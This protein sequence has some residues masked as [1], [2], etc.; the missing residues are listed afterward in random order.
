VPQIAGRKQVYYVARPHEIVRGKSQGGV[1]KRKVGFHSRV[2]RFFI[3][4]LAGK[5]EQGDQEG[6]GG[7][8]NRVI[9]NEGET[10][11]SPLGS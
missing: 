10:R 4:C 8:G 2:H 11:K 6:K 5:E 7:T 9:E 1:K 3:V